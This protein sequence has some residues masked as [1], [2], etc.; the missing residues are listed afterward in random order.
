MA[1]IDS[2]A[3][4]SGDNIRFQG[5]KVTVFVGSKIVTVLRDDFAHIPM[6]N[7]WDLPGGG[8]ENGESP[9]GCAARECVEEV[10]LTLGKTDILWARPYVT[11]DV[12]NWFFVARV[13]AD[14]ATE[15]C[16]GDEG[17]RLTLM[18]VDE[19]LNHPK[20]VPNFQKR[21]SDWI[22]GL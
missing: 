9:W 19:Y 8:R 12:T 21:L 7:R 5:A 6:P 16:L 3:F 18:S 4:Q 2:I 11:N 10:S 15:L 17:Q 14:R 1:D 20:A 22:A 13:A